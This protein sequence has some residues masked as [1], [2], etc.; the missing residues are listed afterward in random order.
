M[1]FGYLTWAK[2]YARIHFDRKDIVFKKLSY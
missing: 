1:F 2:L